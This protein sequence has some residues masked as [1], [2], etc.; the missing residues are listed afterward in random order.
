MDRMGWFQ[1]KYQ[2]QMVD[3]FFF[4]FTSHMKRHTHSPSPHQKKL[5]EILRKKRLNKQQ[6]YYTEP[7]QTKDLNYL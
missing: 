1:M 6:L 4:F 7:Q 3:F 2:K 5:Q